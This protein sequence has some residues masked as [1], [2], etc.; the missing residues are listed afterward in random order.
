[1]IDL[2]KVYF[3]WTERQ[4]LADTQ[5]KEV[6]RFCNYNQTIQWIGQGTVIPLQA[7]LTNIYLINT[8][9]SQLDNW[10]T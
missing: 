4:V 2:G 3:W 9:M 7:N 8:E 10:Q 5:V 1:M 6:I